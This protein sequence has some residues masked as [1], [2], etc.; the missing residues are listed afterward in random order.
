MYPAPPCR[1][2]RDAAVLRRCGLTA[3]PFGRHRLTAGGGAA[4]RLHP[5]PRRRPA[6]T[7]RAWPPSDLRCLPNGINHRSGEPTQPVERP[8][9]QGSTLTLVEFGSHLPSHQPEPTPPA[10]RPP[11]TDSQTPTCS[12]RIVTKHRCKT[13]ITTLKVR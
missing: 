13:G 11:P 6:A 7:A 5:R 9:P 8:W 1:W 12:P 3:P 10:L 2:C 4:I